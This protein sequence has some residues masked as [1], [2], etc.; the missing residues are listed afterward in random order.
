MTRESIAAVY[1]KQLFNILFT[2][3]NNSTSLQVTHK[4][5]FPCVQTLQIVVNT[6]S[7]LLSRAFVLNKFVAARGLLSVTL[8][9]TLPSK[10]KGLKISTF[11][12]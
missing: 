1:A 11:S 6:H 8:R 3:L 10:K 2:T 7:Q 9:R 12:I 5:R 4:G